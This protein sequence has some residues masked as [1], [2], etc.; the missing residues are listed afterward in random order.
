MIDAG[1]DAELLSYRAFL[2]AKR[3]LTN[4]V[5]KRA[6][7]S[8]VAVGIRNPDK[9]AKKLCEVE[10]WRPTGQ[11]WEIAGWLDW[12][13]SAA[14]VAAKVEKR[15]SAGIRGNH[16]K[17]HGDNPDPDCP[18]CASQLASQSATH[19]G[20][21]VASQ[22]LSQTAPQSRSRS[23][24]RSK[25]SSSSHPPVVEFRVTVPEVLD[26]AADRRTDRAEAE[27]KIETN[28]GGYRARIRENL[29]SEL[30][31]AASV[32]IANNPELSVEEIANLID[33]DHRAVREE[34][35]N[36]RIAER[37]ARIA[38]CERIADDE[39]PFT[40]E[41]RQGTPAACAGRAS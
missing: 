28:R 30:G 19:G 31:H 4:G 23:S 7:L 3:A 15:R 40:G 13:D 37:D 33:P 9:L 24:Q 38:E 6:Q 16:V 34:E 18:H 41:P 27:G 32:A 20:T 29:T 25:E 21:D 5:I 36:R 12:N 1:A 10:L 2:F 22:D 26:V 14:D 35:L 17:Y 8:R 11:G 39:D